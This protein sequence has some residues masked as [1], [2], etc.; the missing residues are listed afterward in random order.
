MVI[1]GAGAGILAILGGH[2][3][4]RPDPWLRGAPNCGLQRVLLRLLVLLQQLLLVVMVGGDVWRGS[5]RWPEVVMQGGGMEEWV[6]ARRHA[7]GSV[8]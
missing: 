6:G 3:G 7:A 1:L 2:V 8:V 5:R 4:Q